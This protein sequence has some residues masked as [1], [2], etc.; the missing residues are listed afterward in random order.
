MSDA[1]QKLAARFRAS[2]VERIRRMSLKLLDLAA[3]SASAEAPDEIARDLHTM[4]GEARMVGFP[5]VSE[6]VHA[7][8]DRLKRDRAAGALA[9]AWPRLTRALDALAQ[10]LVADAPDEAALAA[11]AHQLRSDEDAPAQAAESADEPAPSGSAAEEAP[12]PAREPGRGAPAERWIQASARRIDALCETM[13]ELL[14]EFRALYAQARSAPEAHG[15]AFVEDF[16][17]CRQ[18][19]EDVA[20]AAWALRLVPVEPVLAD[21]A[22]H[23]RELAD[24]QQ[25]RV[26]VTV[27]SGGA[28]VE[29]R[30]LDDLWEP[31]VHLVRNAV[32]HGVEPPAERGRKGEEAILAL[33]AE[34]VGSTVSITVSDDGRGVDT[35][36][37][38][39]VAVERALVTAEAAAALTREQ[40]LD[41]LFLHG[42]STRA[43]VSDLSG[44]GVGLDVVRR[45]VEAVG[46]TVTLRSELGLGTRVA[47]AV[48]ASVA[49][50]RALV[51]QCGDG[52]YAIPSRQVLEVVRLAEQPP[53]SVPGGR[54]LRTRAGVVPLRS[55]AAVLGLPAA[56]EPLA[57]V[58]ATGNRHWGFTVEKLAGEWDLVRS[59]CDPLLAA[60]GRLSASAIL[61]DGRLVLHLAVADLVRRADTGAAA[62][63]PPRAAARRP[64]VLVVD[65]SAVIRDLATQII[66]GAGF[67]VTTASDGVR[68][69][70]AVSASQPDA[71][72]SDIDM[73]VMDGFTLLAELHR[74][75]PRLPIIM[76]TSH[77]SAEDRRRAATLGASAY[78]V[79]SSFDEQELLETVKRFVGGAA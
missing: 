60:G 27:D 50:E 12:A 52:L 70:E 65:D 47:I 77:A 48:P 76:F 39:A 79:K 6:V 71:V 19:L 10:A 43:E 3:G 54:A 35:E 53:E 68:A 49:R 18:Q 61:D 62:P 72:L 17:R 13:S 69:L 28:Q 23:V 16:D 41:L 33:A 55:L 42:F 2:A 7:A 78:L 20:G 25:K 74:Q 51:I 64:R 37:V 34:A 8:E 11:L 44:R 40:A 29:Q 59:A 9:R 63:R 67:E 45:A 38:R 46:G 31:L 26:R 57:L 30:V 1:R 73:P 36:Q 14:A 24:A 5:S 15:R 21:L 22:R 58:L 56:E 32:D 4:K 66:T 75:W